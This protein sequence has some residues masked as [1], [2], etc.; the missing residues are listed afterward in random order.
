MNNEWTP[1]DI[2]I[3][4]REYPVRECEEVA[5]M[6]GRSVRATYIMAYRLGLKKHH[7]GVFWTP[8]MLKLLNDYYPIMFNKP[9]A[10]WIGVS[11]RSLIRKAR[12]LGLEKRPNFLEDRREDIVELARE[13]LKKA[14]REGK[15]TTTFKKGIRFYPEGEFKKGQVENPE[16]KAKRIAGVKAAWKKRKQQEKFRKDYNINVK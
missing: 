6:L 13:G 14:Y 4:R 12:K 9:L 3:M 7:H 11:E 5:A 1:R 10:A 8:R 2:D 16:T 15:L